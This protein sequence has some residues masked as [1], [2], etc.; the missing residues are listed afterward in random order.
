[1]PASNDTDL[2][3]PCAR[4]TPLPASLTLKEGVT[5]RGLALKPTDTRWRTLPSTAPPPSSSSRTMG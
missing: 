4:S 5:P 3:A 2:R 1:M